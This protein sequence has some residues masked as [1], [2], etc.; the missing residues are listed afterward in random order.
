MFLHFSHLQTAEQETP[1]KKHSQYFFLHPD[2][3]QLHPLVQVNLLCLKASG[4]LSMASLMALTLRTLV[5]LLLHFLHLQCLVHCRL[6]A[7]H[8]QYNFKHLV[9]EQLQ[10]VR[11][12]VDCGRSSDIETSWAL[13]VNPDITGSDFKQY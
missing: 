13:E 3:L 4:F 1:F 6:L 9:F 11:G 12:K 2:I 8:S 10:P 7:K 5:L